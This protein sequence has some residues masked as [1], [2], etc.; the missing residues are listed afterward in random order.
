VKVT[1]SALQNAASVAALLLTTESLVADIPEKGKK[2]DHHD[3]HHGMG[4]GMGGMEAWVGWRH[5]D[6]RYGHVKS[7]LEIRNPKQSEIPM[8]E[9]RDLGFRISDLFRI[10]DFEFRILHAHIAHPMPP[11]HPCLPCTH[12]AAMP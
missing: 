1:R 11:S 7:E 12:A 10:S 4:G 9:R 2:D 8:T 6:G 5:G 3:D